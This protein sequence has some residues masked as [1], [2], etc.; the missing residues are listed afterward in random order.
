VDSPA[1][2]PPL[3]FAEDLQMWDR[4]KGQPI[5]TISFDVAVTAAEGT[6]TEGGIGVFVARSVLA[7]KVNQ[8]KAM[9]Q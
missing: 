8:L 5:Q 1:G 2:D 4:T 3:N 9:R 7:R 6:K